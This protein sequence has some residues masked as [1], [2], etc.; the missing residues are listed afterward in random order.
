[1]VFTLQL[2]ENVGGKWRG[3]KTVGTLGGCACPLSAVEVV[4]RLP[5]EYV[6]CQINLSWS[7]SACFKSQE[8]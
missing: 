7:Y 6:F 3:K 1:M 4:R 2:Y 8:K 5:F